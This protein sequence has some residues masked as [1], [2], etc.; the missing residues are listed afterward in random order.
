[1]LSR[2]ILAAALAAAFGGAAAAQTP[3]GGLSPEGRAILAEAMAREDVPAHNAA[4]MRARTRVLELLAASELD[5][6]EIE[7]AQEEER[8]LVMREHARAHAR[9]RDAYEQLS[10]SDRKAFAAAVAL[11]EA[12][13][14][15]QMAQAKDRMERIDRLMEYQMRRVAEMR[16]RER[17]QRR[18]AQQVSD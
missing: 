18:R 12:R 15:A 6:D 11:R 2:L 9:M 10:A 1:M 13:M 8:R 3:F 7:E 14:R 4:I 16:A 17:A 5:I